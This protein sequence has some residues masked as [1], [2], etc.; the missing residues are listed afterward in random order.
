MNYTR[1][2]PSILLLAIISIAVYVNS[3]SNGFVFDDEDTVV[4][5]FLIKDIH[6]LPKLFKWEYFSISGETTY[7]P[8]VTLS[9]FIDYAIFNL[10][11]WGFHLTNVLLH[12]A[13]VILAYILLTLTVEPFSKIES[14]PLG[15]KKFIN[16]QALLTSMLFAV[17]PAL[18]ETVNAISFREDL[19]VFFFYIAAFNIYIF[20]RLNSAHIQRTISFLCYMVSAALYFLALLSKEMAATFPLIILS[21]ELIIG[22]KKENIKRSALL[23]YYNIGYLLITLIAA[24]IYYN[25]HKPAIYAYY[26]DLS[27]RLL[28][29]PWLL[30]YYIKVALFPVSLSADYNITQVTSAFSFSFIIPAITIASL[31]VKAL[32]IRKR[33]PII[34]FGILFFIFTLIPVYNIIPL[35]N[36]VAERYLYL[37]LL[38][39]AMV[40]GTVIFKLLNLLAR[41][42]F[43]VLMIIIAI[44]AL[45]SFRTI[46]RNTVWKDSYSLWTATIR[47]MPY[48]GLAH[49][50]LA[51]IYVSQNKIDEAMK[52]YQIALKLR[53]ADPKIHLNL[54]NRYLKSG[55][56]DKAIKEYVIS[57]QLR[58]DLPD[59]HHGLGKAYAVLGKYDEAEKEY[60]KAIELNPYKADFRNDLGTAY[61]NQARFEEALQQFQAAIK[62]KPQY[63]EGH[64]NLAV[65]YASLKAFD[66]AIEHYKIVISLDK[67][68]LAAYINLGSVYY[69]AGLID[70]AINQY[71]AALRLKQDSLEAHYNLGF[72]LKAKGKIEEARVEFET[73]LELKPDFLPARKALESL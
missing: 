14:R 41:L 56:I 70:D 11:P 23:N 45:Y 8:V 35:R 6:N 37:P 28:T 50:N 71:R 3:I 57:L 55:Q 67:N 39:F 30:F 49:N 18:T 72:A 40:V 68:D 33:E 26:W 60:K 21:Y 4:G 36:P 31:F 5:N 24:F 64:Y 65:T 22:G 9:Y 38:G 51:V 61:A 2:L 53:P 19:L 16:N 25:F 54:G 20:L 1:H 46:V 17:H 47:T 12:A 29:I 59:A 15:I 58:T 32:L 44:V 69:E 66:K 43:S 42:C 48:S 52:H 62:L 10:K 63:L 13:N 73:V 7:R 27:E 34:S